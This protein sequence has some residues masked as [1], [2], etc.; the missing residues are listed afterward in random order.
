MA[1]D[2]VNA[3]IILALETAPRP[4][5]PADFAARVARK[6][7]PRGALMLTPAR[8]GQLAALACLVMLPVLM[9]AFAHQAAGTSFYWVS[10][11]WI[12]SAQSVL[13][14]AWMAMRGRV[15]HGH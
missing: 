13:L 6:L 1:E 15:T 11:E 5:I 10:M 4:E 8:Y 3:R 14:A 2:K 7:P 12:F 9:F